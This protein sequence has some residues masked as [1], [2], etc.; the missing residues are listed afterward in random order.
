MR[1]FFEHAGGGQATSEIGTTRK[2]ATRFTP[3]LLTTAMPYLNECCL[4]SRYWGILG[5][6]SV[7]RR[8]HMKILYRRILIA[9]CDWQ[10]C[11][12][13]LMSILRSDCHN[14]K[15]RYGQ[16]ARDWYSNDDR[17]ANFPSNHQSQM[18]LK[19]TASSVCH[20]G[21]YM[22]LVFWDRDF[23]TWSFMRLVL[24]TNLKLLNNCWYW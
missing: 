4:W 5:I 10:Q 7:Q 17:L 2:Q 15:R 8:T 16:N 14:I 23:V 11:L 22:Y 3:S 6:F 1:T 24:S 13:L 20:I 19:E 18:D 12:L 21:G 9:N